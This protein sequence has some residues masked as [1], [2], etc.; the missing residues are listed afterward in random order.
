[1]VEQ[2]DEAVQ[3]VVHVLWHQ[4]QQQHGGNGA[5]GPGEQQQ[6]PPQGKARYE[7]H[8][9]EDE[10]E[11]QA[12]SH[13]V[14]NHEIQPA[15]A[16]GVG[17]H[18]EG[19]AERLQ[20]LLLLPEPLDLFGQQQ[21]KGNFHHLRRADLEGHKGEFQP[22]PVSGVARDAKGRPQEE[23]EDDVKGQNPLPLPGDGLQ[24]QHGEENIHADAE[25]QGYALDDHAPEPRG[26]VHVPGG[27]EYQRDTVQRRGAA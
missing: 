21:D 10:H 5:P 9:E 7:G 18:K 24:I 16:Q 14:G 19:G 11:N 20:V 1:M 25:A 15:E 22:G 23:D 13:I 3:H 4:V 6:E 27:A 2:D 8:A 17:R 12:V 26:G